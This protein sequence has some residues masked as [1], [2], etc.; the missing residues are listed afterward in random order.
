M[1]HIVPLRDG[2][3]NDLENFQAVCANCHALKTLKENQQYHDTKRRVK[4]N[5]VFVPF[6]SSRGLQNRTLREEAVLKERVVTE[7]KLAAVLAQ[8]LREKEALDVELHQKQ[9][10]EK[11]V[12]EEVAKEM[13]EAKDDAVRNT[14][15]EKKELSN[16]EDQ[17]VA[18]KD[19]ETASLDKKE[20]AS[21]NR[22][23]TASFDKKDKASPNRKEK[24]SFEK[25]HEYEQESQQEELVSIV[26][27]V[28]QLRKRQ[29]QTLE[30]FRFC[31]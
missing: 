17:E 4:P 3:K 13:E 6:V 2:G 7:R 16:N 21:P 25:Q 15:S 1:D 24:A 26:M 8:Q 10:R 22:K 9:L 12:V 23:E 11:R 29:L 31:G 27:T 5:R 14:T 20:T 18:L 28:N 19:E 30:T